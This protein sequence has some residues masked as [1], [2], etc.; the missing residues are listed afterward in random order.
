MT[1]DKT[2]KFLCRNRDEYSKKQSEV[3]FLW[4]MLRAGC[5]EYAVTHMYR[6]ANERSWYASDYLKRG[7]NVTQWSMTEEND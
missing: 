6:S 1:S 2:D 7:Y 3:K 5:G 4:Y